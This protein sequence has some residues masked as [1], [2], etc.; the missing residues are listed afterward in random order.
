MECLY[1]SSKNTEDTYRSRLEKA[2]KT[3]V[4]ILWS[5]YYCK[6]C[7]NFFETIEKKND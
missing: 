6:D 7:D 4:A 5:I 2:T 1:C 3:S